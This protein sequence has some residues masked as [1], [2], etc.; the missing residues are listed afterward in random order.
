M[1]KWLLSVLALVFFI[2]VSF[3]DEFLMF[4]DMDSY[5]EHYTAVYFLYYTGVVEGYATE[6][7]DREYH[8]EQEINRAEFLKIILEGSGWVVADV[9]T[10]C[11]PDVPVD[12]WYA[13]YVC[14]AKRA[15]WIDGYPDGYFRPEQTINQAEAVKIL[16]EV[17]EWS[18]T[19][20]SEIWYE[21]YEDFAYGRNILWGDLASNLMSRGDIAELIFRSELVEDLSIPAYT[22]DYLGEYFDLF[23]VPYEKISDESSEVFAILDDNGPQTADGSDLWV[24]LTLTDENGD[25]MT[26]HTLTAIVMS[27]FNVKEESLIEDADG[28]YTLVLN[29]TSAG[30]LGVVIHDEDSG[31]FY[32]TEVEF[33]P[34]EAED[35]MVFD[36]Y[37][38]YETEDYS[39]WFQV[40]LVDEYGNV[41]TGEEGEDMDFSSE[42]ELYSVY[43]DETGLW[44]VRVSSGE[45]GSVE[46]E[47]SSGTFYSSLEESMSFDFESVFLG[48]PRAVQE[49]EDFTVPVIVNMG[50][51]GSL[52][53]YEIQLAYD[54]THLFLEEV[55]DG[56]TEDIFDAPIVS[57]GDGSILLSGETSTGEETSQYV[58][59]ADVLFNGAVL[60]GSTIYIE[61]AVLTDIDEELLARVHIAE[62]EVVVKGSKNICLDAYVL[63]GADDV[64]EFVALSDVSYAEQ[65]FWFAADACNCPFF[66]DI[67]VNY[68]EVSREEWSFI[69]AIPGL[70]EGGVED[71]V[72]T[73]VEMD[74]LAE[75]FTD[76]NDCINWFFVPQLRT[77]DPVGAGSVVVG[78]SSSNPKYIVSDHSRDIKGRNL[79]HELVH[80]LSGNEAE[81]FDPVASAEANHQAVNQ[82]ANGPNN[83][84]NYGG[85]GIGISANQCGVIDWDDL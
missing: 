68:H 36:R 53:S 77:P 19:T 58:H 27:E 74:E 64:D 48:V 60:G 69:T 17:S 10:S 82:G 2:P 76:G 79:G 34:G 4:S 38:A 55:G 54:P 33:V 30:F 3:G 45:L 12:E 29:S 11:F 35:I 59:V 25:A 56:D 57:M 6:E 51:E 71:D 5:D 52:G 42:G 49:G 37:E 14:E 9:S 22:E 61:D 70:D 44:D 43:D 67:D 32:S 18:L 1:G 16:G 85:A 21:P 83:I 80:R 24:T 31:E 8:S 50:S 84:M 40:G 72:I 66:L 15:G 63:E 75:S 20:T 39:A 78:W 7:G 65:A 73:K 13:G 41:L 62:P 47:L 28:L 23:G 46:V 81:D 26:G